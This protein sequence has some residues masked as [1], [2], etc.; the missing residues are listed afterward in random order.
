[1]VSGGELSN[2]S[3][4]GTSYSATFTPNGD[5][6]KTIDVAAGSASEAALE[7]L[8]DDIDHL[9]TYSGF[10]GWGTAINGDGTVIAVGELGQ[11]DFSGQ[12]RVLE[13]ADDSWTQI[14]DTISLE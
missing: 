5:G 7:Q 14:G 13:Y 11:T 3:G 6:V 12:V 9:A 8:G 10:E 1:M 2:F 4:S